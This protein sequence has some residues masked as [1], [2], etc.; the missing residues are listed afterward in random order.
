MRAAQ[1]VKDVWEKNEGIKEFK[2]RV[3]SYD[4]ETEKVYKISCK[5][6]GARLWKVEDKILQ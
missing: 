1:N 5:P 2:N 6:L 4:L 3:L